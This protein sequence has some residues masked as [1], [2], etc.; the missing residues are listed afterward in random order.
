L[1]WWQHTTKCFEGSK[2]FHGMACFW[3]L[4]FLGFFSNK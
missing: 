1:K 3:S 4:N 2:S